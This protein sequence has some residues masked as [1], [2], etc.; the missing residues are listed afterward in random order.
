VVVTDL[1]VEDETVSPEQLADYSVLSAHFSSLGFV[2][3]LETSLEIERLGVRSLGIRMDVTSEENIRDVVNKVS[4]VF[5]GVDILVNNAAVMDGHG[6][7]EN[8]STKTWERDLRVNLTGAFLCSRALWPGMK[9]RNWG[10]IINL[11]SFTAESGAFA[12]P[13]YGASKAGLLGLTRSLA[14]EGARHGITVNAVMP[15]FIATEAVNLYQQD[16]KDRICK[17]NPMKR[18]GKPEEVASVVSFLASDAAGYING[19]S[20][21][22]T[23][24]M[25][26][27][28]F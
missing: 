19:V 9:K 6:L 5:G 16:M 14:L 11:S 10:R 25:D 12:L 22:V 8:Q 28:V 15:G 4:E 24:G 18:M 17:R 27:L 26:L 23:G 21:P 20:L 1:L 2:K 7:L 3:T 13:G